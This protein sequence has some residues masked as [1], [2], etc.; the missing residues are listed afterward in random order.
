MTAGRIDR[1]LYNRTGVSGVNCV[2]DCSHLK[3]V[4]HAIF[5]NIRLVYPAVDIVVAVVTSF[6]HLAKRF[7]KTLL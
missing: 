3:N 6:I 2:S 4:Q 5:S 1:R 7:F